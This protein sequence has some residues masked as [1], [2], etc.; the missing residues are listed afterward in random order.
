MP[1]NRHAL[2]TGSAQSRLDPRAARCHTRPVPDSDLREFI[3]EITLRHEKASRDTERWLRIADRRTDE[4]VRRTD[5]M[6]RK[7]DEMVRKGDEMIRKGD[8][9]IA[10]LRDLRAESQAQRAALFRM[11]DRLGPGGAEPA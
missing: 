4:M 8:A 1:S 7:G 3:R 2:D 10:E 6:I 11:L 5:E 9:V